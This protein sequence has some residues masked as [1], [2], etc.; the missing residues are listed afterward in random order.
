MFTHRLLKSCSQ[1]TTITQQKKEKL[2]KL[3]QTAASVQQKKLQR[4]KNIYKDANQ[5]KDISNEH[6][7]KQNYSK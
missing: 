5:H 6:A 7:Q 3:G 1:K 2:D 4:L